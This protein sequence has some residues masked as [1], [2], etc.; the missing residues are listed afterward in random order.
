[1][2]GIP[3]EKSNGII[4]PTIPP[5]P[6]MSVKLVPPIM[7]PGIPGIPPIAYCGGGVMPATVR[8]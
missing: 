7:P 2:S 1:M 4:P 3:P 5:S 8:A 6:N